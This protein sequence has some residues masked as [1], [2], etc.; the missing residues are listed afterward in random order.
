[1]FNQSSPH[2]LQDACSSMR[3]KVSKKQ[4]GAP[5]VAR[6]FLVSLRLR[7]GGRTIHMPAYLAQHIRQPDWPQGRQ[8]GRIDMSA[9]DLVR[10]GGAEFGPACQLVM[11]FQQQLQQQQQYLDG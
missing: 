4:E 8:N 3:M 9:E 2:A 5:C 6:A 7:A 11:C 10:S 1:M